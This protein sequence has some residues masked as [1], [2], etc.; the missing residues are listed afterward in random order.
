MKNNGKYVKLNIVWSANTLSAIVLGALPGRRC[1]NN[2]I[3]DGS[4]AKLLPLAYFV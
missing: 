2:G 4:T 1:K 3:S